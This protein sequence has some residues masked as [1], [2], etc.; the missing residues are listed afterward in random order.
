MSYCRYG[1][2]SD[3]YLFQ[4]SAGYECMVSGGQTGFVVK[5]PTEALRKLLSLRNSGLKVPQGGIDRL[6]REIAAK[7]L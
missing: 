3:V 7:H 6:E 5:T 1:E 4:S 2:D